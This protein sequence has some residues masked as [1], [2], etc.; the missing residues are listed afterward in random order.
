MSIFVNLCTV[1]NQYARVEL[2]ALIAFAIFSAKVWE[3][4]LQSSQRTRRENR[5]RTT[6]N[7]VAE[8]CGLAWTDDGFCFFLSRNLS[9]WFNDWK[10]KWHDF[11]D[12][13]ASKLWESVD[14]HGFCGPVAWHDKSLPGEAS[15]NV[16]FKLAS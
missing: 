15:D 5:V 8:E 11:V 3:L 1:I 2:F 10:S 6:N 7:L 4:W 9:G 16:K 13:S 12:F 14:P